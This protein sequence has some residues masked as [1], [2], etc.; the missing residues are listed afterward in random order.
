MKNE[1]DDKGDF[2]NGGSQAGKSPNGLE[3]GST[4]DPFDPEK[5]RLSQ[6]YGGQLGVRMEILTV[7]VRKP[8]KTWWVRVRPGEEF[9]LQTLLLDLEEENESYLLDPK[10]W[11]DLAF[12]GV[13]R[14]SVMF[15]SVTRDG[16]L[17]LWKVRMPGQDGKMNPWWE[18]ALRAAQKAET[19]WVRVSANMQLGAYNVFA[20]AAELPDPT[21]PEITFSEV[22]R[23]A[24][25][26]RYIDSHDHAVLRQLRG[27]L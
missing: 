8:A 11:P 13:V 18:S 22:L 4:A 1:N 24:F 17:F 19:E 6:D 21:W 7:P 14:P 3:T 10:L 25:K 27:E 23:V 15:L 16:V 12:E 5:L 20:A 9:R 2:E 26:G